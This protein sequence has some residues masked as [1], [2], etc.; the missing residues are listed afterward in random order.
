MLSTV[1]TASFA[2]MVDWTCCNSVL[3]IRDKS[4][5]TGCL[6]DVLTA[7]LVLEP[8]SGGAVTITV[9]YTLI[10]GLYDTPYQVAQLSSHC[11]NET[12]LRHEGPT[13]TSRYPGIH[14]PIILGLLR[15]KCDSWTS[16]E[17]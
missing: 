6:N 5:R 10:G 13:K 1:M 7:D 9:G 12:T 3:G 15:L 4:V 2:A 14:F 8:N 16:A 11:P 17:T